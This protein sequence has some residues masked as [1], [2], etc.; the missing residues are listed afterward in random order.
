[1]YIRVLDS[2]AKSCTILRGVTDAQKSPKSG[3]QAITPPPVAVA[4]ASWAAQPTISP[5]FLSVQEGTTRSIGMS[6]CA[7]AQ[8]PDV[9]RV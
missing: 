8:L 9:V 4:L 7:M 3:D 5:S 1:V 2:K 6:L